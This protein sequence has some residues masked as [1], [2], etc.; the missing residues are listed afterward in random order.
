MK[1][2]QVYK[3]TKIRVRIDQPKGTVHNHID[4]FNDQFSYDH[5]YW[6]IC[7]V[8]LHVFFFPQWN[9]HGGCW[10]KKSVN[11]QQW[12][13]ATCAVASAGTDF[14]FS[15]F[16]FLIAQFDTETNGVCSPMLLSFYSVKLEFSEGKIVF[17]SIN[18]QVWSSLSNYR[19]CLH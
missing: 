1:Y 17:G 7:R 6:E 9:L 16:F 12:Q 19:G 10:E 15:W 2:V 4:T 14:S 3:M 8:T 18:V 13:K 11:R 5:K